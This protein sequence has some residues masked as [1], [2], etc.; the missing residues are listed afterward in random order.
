MRALA[1]SLRVWCQQPIGT[2]TEDEAADL[3]SPKAARPQCSRDYPLVT[4][5][6]RAKFANKGRFDQFDEAPGEPANRQGS[7]STSEEIAYK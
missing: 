1:R 3:V 7:G 6:S 5:S 2:L 4:N